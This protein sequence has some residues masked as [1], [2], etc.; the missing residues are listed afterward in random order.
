M[1]ASVK[2]SMVPRE[3]DPARRQA[4]RSGNSFLRPTLRET[5]APRLFGG[6]RAAAQIPNRRQPHELRREQYG[7][8]LITYCC[9]LQ[10]HS[11]AEFANAL[12]R[13][14]DWPFLF[15]PAGNG[16]SIVLPLALLLV[17]YLLGQAFRLCGWLN[18][19]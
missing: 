12:I 7:D 2:N 10:A 19:C 17:Y 5:L 8:A 13:Q 11:F 9:P 4:P 14:L 1:Q 6:N 18:G 15:T 16:I 3:T